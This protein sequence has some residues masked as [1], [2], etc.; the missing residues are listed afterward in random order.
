MPSVLRVTS[1]AAAPVRA[2]PDNGIEARLPV[3][4]AAAA[5]PTPCSTINRG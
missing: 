3:T 1:M 2:A 4:G 5:G